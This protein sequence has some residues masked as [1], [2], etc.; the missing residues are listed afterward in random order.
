MECYIPTTPR[1]EHSYKCHPLATFLFH[2]LL[3]RESNK[4]YNCELISIWLYYPIQMPT[5][6]CQR[7]SICYWFLL[8]PPQWGVH[9]TQVHQTKWKT[10]ACLSYQAV[11]CWRHRF[12]QRWKGSSTN[13]S[14]SHLKNCRCCNPQNHKPKEWTHGADPTPTIHRTRRHS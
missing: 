7:L 4:S 2:I 13:L 9:Q 12:L 3:R 10:S 5:P 8:P 11:L 6:V 1:T 14:P